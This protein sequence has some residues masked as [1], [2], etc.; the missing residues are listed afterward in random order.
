MINNK[1]RLKRNFKIKLTNKPLSPFTKVTTEKETI[2]LFLN[3]Y[4]NN[5]EI[6]NYFSKTARFDKNII[7]KLINKSFEYKYIR[8]V[9]KVNIKNRIIKNSVLLINENSLNNIL[10]LYLVKEPDDYSTWKI[11]LMELE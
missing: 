7:E 6:N 9:K 2:K 11:V 5:L 4:R 1:N 3:A 10:H 8:Q